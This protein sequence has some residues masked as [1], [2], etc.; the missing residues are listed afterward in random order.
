MI[1]TACNHHPHRT[2]CN[3]C[4]DKN[5]LGALRAEVALL[6]QERD[7][8]IREIGPAFAEIER[9]KKEREQMKQEHD[10]AFAKITW[11]RE[12]LADTVDLA[13][14]AMRDANRDGCE[15]EQSWLDYARAAVK[16]QP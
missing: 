12:L 9:L 8:A 14:S 3:E 15:Y 5:E 10:A 11:L 16:E 2:L 6:K 1:I 4:L 7:A 13:S